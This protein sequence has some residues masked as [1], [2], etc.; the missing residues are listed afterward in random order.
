MGIFGIFIVDVCVFIHSIFLSVLNQIL[1][2][3]YM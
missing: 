3:S 1:L 2:N